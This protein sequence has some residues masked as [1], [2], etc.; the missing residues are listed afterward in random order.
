[1]AGLGWLG[2]T[3]PEEYGGTGG[4]FLDLLP[5]YEEMGRFLVP[6]PHL[7]TVAG[8]GRDDPE[9][10]HRRAEAALA[11]ADRRRSLH[12]QP[13]GAGGRRRVRPRRHHV[14]GAIQRQRLRAHRHEVAGGVRAVGRP[15]PRGRAHER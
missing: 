5:I 15:L 1:M 7:D 9:R 14:L 4:R 10:R 2:I 8:R 12:H 3:I 6:S 13:R 11:P